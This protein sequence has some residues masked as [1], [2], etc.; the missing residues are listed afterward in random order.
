MTALMDV[1]RSKG[2]KRM[3]GEVLATN[4]AMLQLVASLAFTITTSPDDPAVKRVTKQ[5]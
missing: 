1:A 2:L 4:Q 5:L 3:E